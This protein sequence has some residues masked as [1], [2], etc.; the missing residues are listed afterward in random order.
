MHLHDVLR[1]WREQILSPNPRLGISDDE[2]RLVPAELS[3]GRDRVTVPG[4][5][6]R[7]DSEAMQV[8]LF[9]ARH[10]PARPATDDALDDLEGT[11]DFPIPRPVELLLRLHDGGDFFVT[12][13]EALPPELREPFHLLSAQEIGVAYEQIIAG[14]RRALEGLDRED[15]ELARVASRFGAKGPARDALMEELEAVLDGAEAGLQIVPLLRAPGTQNYVT[16]VPHLGKE[17]RVGYAFA[18]A[19]YLPE[20]SMEYAFDGLEGWL[21]AVLKAHACRRVVLT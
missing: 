15:D 9:P 5:L 13:E 16:F 7:D 4:K 12:T 14:V 8:A 19:G 21:Y 3:A 18:E 17:G 11:L 1:A 6:R 10:A 20:D 2:L